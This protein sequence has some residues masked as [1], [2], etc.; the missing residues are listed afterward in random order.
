MRAMFY[1]KL[2][3]HFQ[4]NTYMGFQFQINANNLEGM[5]PG[6]VHRPFQ[7]DDGLVS[8]NSCEIF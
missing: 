1:L 5:L 3:I 6:V 8:C 4:E 2:R 7:G